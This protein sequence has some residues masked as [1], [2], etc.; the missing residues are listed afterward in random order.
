MLVPGSG[1]FGICIL[2]FSWKHEIQRQLNIASNSTYCSTYAVHLCN[3]VS[4]FRGHIRKSRIC[5]SS[6]LHQLA[7]SKGTKWKYGKRRVDFLKAQLSTLRRK[8]IQE[9]GRAE[10]ERARADR[11]EESLAT[12]LKTHVAQIAERLAAIWQIL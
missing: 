7:C 3:N 6:W 10:L 8:L 5:L 11:A 12:W 9:R 2:T 1:I 4:T